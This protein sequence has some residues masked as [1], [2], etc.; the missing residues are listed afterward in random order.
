MTVFPIAA[1]AGLLML[2]PAANA[3]TPRRD[4]NWEITIDVELD[5]VAGRIPTRTTTQCI[6]RDEVASGHHAMPGHESLPGACSASDHKVD[7]NR[8]SWTFSCATPQ[9]VSGS[10]EIVYT[11]EHAY[12]G[13]I[14]FTRDGKTMTMKYEGK[15]LGECA[16]VTTR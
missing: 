10:G 16:A 8:V 11:N 7:G 14:V 3:Q 9:P 4:G 12:K 1:L 6:T 5:G 2:P 13:S 15:R